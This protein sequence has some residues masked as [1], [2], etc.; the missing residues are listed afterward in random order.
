MA[1]IYFVH[2]KII[3][4]K[5]VDTYNI[6]RWCWLEGA[7]W[8]GVRQFIFLSLRMFDTCDELAE[9]CYLCAVWLVRFCCCC[10][11]NDQVHHEEDDNNELLLC[12]LTSFPQLSLIIYRLKK[13]FPCHVWFITKKTLWGTGAA[14]LYTE[15]SDRMQ[16]IL[17]NNAFLMT[18]LYWVDESTQRV[19]NFHMS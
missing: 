7:V 14:S 6:T 9:A 2:V 19:W 1:S 12:S 11:S 17:K 8:P 5:C 13:K 3:S 16:K 4:M 18:R 15:Q 10:V